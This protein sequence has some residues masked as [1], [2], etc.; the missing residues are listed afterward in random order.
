MQDP[1]GGSE[2]DWEHLSVLLGIAVAALTVLLRLKWI[3][4]QFSNLIVWMGRK[5]TLALLESDTEEAH[6]AL[7]KLLPELP[8]MRR[9]L[10]HLEDSVVKLEETVAQ[11]DRDMR[12]G[13]RDIRE[14]VAKDG[15]QLRSDF[16]AVAIRME[17]GA[18]E[19]RE[20]MVSLRDT[21]HTLTGLVAGDAGLRRAVRRAVGDAR[22]LREPEGE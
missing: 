15:A 21:V 20:G 14:T 8:E 16:H 12:N 22:V 10:G 6:A 13:A 7:A 19:M 4:K 9:T 11:V 1:T 3:G 17:A 2:I 5:A 18:R